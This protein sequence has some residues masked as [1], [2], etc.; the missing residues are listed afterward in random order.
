MYR[1]VELRNTC[2]NTYV[3]QQST[4]Y[5]YLDI[6]AEQACNAGSTDPWIICKISTQK[7]IV[8]FLE[9]IGLGL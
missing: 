1:I 8:P 9:L 4:E 2:I 5:E 6:C 3:L 7:V